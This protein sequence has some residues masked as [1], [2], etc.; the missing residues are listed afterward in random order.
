MPS[1]FAWSRSPTQDDEARSTRACKRRRLEE[2]F[3]QQSDIE[4][5]AAEEIVTSSEQSS[6]T[7]VRT[8]VL[9]AEYSSSDATTQCAMQSTFSAWKFRHHPD[10]IH[11]YTGLE[12]YE[13]FVFVRQTL[14]PAQDELIY[15]HGVRPTLS[16]EEQFFLTLVKL[17]Q[18]KVNFEL[19]CLFDITERSVTNVFVTW[20][21]FMA[22]SW[23]EIDWWPFRDTVRFY[24]PTDFCAK[25]PTTRVIVDGTE[26]PIQKPKQPIAQQATFS[27]YKN[28]N[29]VK[30]LVGCTPGGLVSYVSPAYGGSTSDRQIVERSEL[31]QACDPGDSI[32]ADKGF[33]VQDLFIPFDVLIN[34]PSFFKKKNRLSGETVMSDRKIASKRVHIERIIG[35]AKTFKMLQQPMTNTES[36]LSTQIIK[37]C[38]I[39]CNFRARIVPTDA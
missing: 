8:P 9:V 3:N 37:I 21:N 7:V 38:F 16:V 35:L 14:G 1:I 32:M 34:I 25:F 10:A 19:S 22:V 39:L 15:Y 33:N 24:S 4:N 31:L 36:A 6:S 18:N 5:V 23:D 11:F 13:K 30:V 28:R 2:E 12:S 26:C 20:V 17:R 29:T 27:T